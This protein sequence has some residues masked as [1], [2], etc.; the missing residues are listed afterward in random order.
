MGGGSLTAEALVR[1]GAEHAARNRLTASVQSRP[2][3]IRITMS[4]GGRKVK[5][6]GYAIKRLGKAAE[7]GRTPKRYRAI[8]CVLRHFWTTEGL[9]ILGLSTRTITRTIK[10]KIKITRTEHFSQKT[11]NLGH[12]ASNLGECLR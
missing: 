1:F 6:G 3:R 7:D 4:G 8:Q 11:C 10:I 12:F 9:A 2:M 5:V